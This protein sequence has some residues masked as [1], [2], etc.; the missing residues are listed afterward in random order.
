MTASGTTLVCRAVTPAESPPKH[1]AQT[2]R[3]RAD[4]VRTEPVADN[5]RFLWPRARALQGPLEHR[6]MGLAP[7]DAA[8]ARDPV[9][10]IPEPEASPVL[11]DLVVA[12]PQRVRHED[13]AEPLRP[14]PAPP[15][16]AP[17][18]SRAGVSSGTLQTE[19]T[20]SRSISSSEMPWPRSQRSISA[21]VSWRHGRSWSSG[22]CFAC[23]KA[24]YTALAGAPGRCLEH[25]LGSP[26]PSLRRACRRH[27]RTRLVDPPEYRI[28]GVGLRAACVH[29]EVA[30]ARVARRRDRA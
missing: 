25:A 10:K 13:H 29:R 8:R 16:P 1:R 5:H 22:S 9:D 27:R 6:R 14:A 23:G 3:L 11:A 30:S 28:D 4:Q 20:V 7:A 15:S 24:S 26:D 21:R 12:T 19:R 17:S 18:V 2:E